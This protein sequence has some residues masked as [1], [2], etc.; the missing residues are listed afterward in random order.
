MLMQR[1]WGAKGPKPAKKLYKLVFDRLT[2][3]LI[4]I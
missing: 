3:S 2:L 4:H 1:Q